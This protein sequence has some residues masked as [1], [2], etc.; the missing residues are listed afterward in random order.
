MF[1][2]KRISWQKV[3][4]RRAK[5]LRD[6]GNG[7][8][9][10][11]FRKVNPSN[12][13]ISSWRPGHFS[14]E[15]VAVG[16]AN[17]WIARDGSLKKKRKAKISNISVEMYEGESHKKRLRYKAYSWPVARARS[18]VCGRRLAQLQSKNET[19]GELGHACPGSFVRCLDLFLDP[20][21]ARSHT[22]DAFGRKA[23]T[24]SALCA[25]KRR[26]SG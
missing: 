15:L 23:Q 25:E 3:H 21:L 17:A 16:A 20:N 4:G 26:A 24:V 22:S 1:G 8:I 12:M 18:V 6:D 14:K 7:P 5:H 13:S 10:A 11:I 2:W 19:S 9:A